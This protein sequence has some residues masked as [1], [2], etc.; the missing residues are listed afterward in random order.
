MPDDYYAI[1][2]VPKTAR[3]D[4]IKKSYSKFARDNHPDRFIVPEE[5]LDADRRFQLITEA[6]N[7]LLDEKISAKSMRRAFRSRYEHPRR[8]HGYTSRTASSGSS[9]GTSRM[10]CASTKR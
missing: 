3:F 8:R 2:Q 6:Y 5:R 9:Q 1:L 10:P 7:Q 4:E